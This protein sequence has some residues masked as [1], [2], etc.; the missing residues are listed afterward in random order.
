MK[1]LKPAIRCVSATIKPLR[2]DRL[3]GDRWMR[4]RASIL[5]RDGG[6]CR[7]ARC[8]V[9]RQTDPAHALPAHEVD[10]VT[11]LDEG[12]SNDPSNLRAINRECH[13]LKSADDRRRMSSR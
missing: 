8:E 11:P 7:C 3:P 5:Q 10:H 6:I 4:L 13:R 1:M 9:I 12:G 2:V